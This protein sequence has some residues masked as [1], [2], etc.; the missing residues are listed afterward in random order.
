MHHT[1]G[2]V[3]LD[4]LNQLSD[5]SKVAVQRLEE[6]GKQ[7]GKI[8]WPDVDYPHNK[9]A[10]V[11]VVLFEGASG[12]LEVLLT[13]RSTSLRT[14]GGQTALPG[15][16]ADE[17]ENNPVDT[18]FREAFEE[19][20]LPPATRGQNVHV[21]TAISP[22]PSL[23][24][25]LVVPVVALLTDPPLVAALQRTLNAEE[26]DAL[27]IHP[28]HAVLD[29]TVAA[30][31]GIELSKI[32]GQDW[33]YTDELYNTNDVQWFRPGWN[34]RMHRFRTTHSPIKGLTAD[35]LLQVAQI[36]YDRPPTFERNAPDQHP[37][38]EMITA[39]VR[40][41]HDTQQNLDA[42]AYKPDP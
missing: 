25:L 33:P 2:P 32:G 35:I 6:H 21:L 23:H 27:F 26:V 17:G 39:I 5:N 13:T 41:Y 12:E 30:A 4:A 38:S 8:Q 40:E 3:P 34:Y 42:E 28:L 14:H 9:F 31:P 20:G 7:A 24:R 16:K 10:A 1:N 29:P 36:A 11:L 37:F 22:F 15:G 19:I 18:A